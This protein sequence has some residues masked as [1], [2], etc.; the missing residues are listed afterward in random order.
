MNPGGDQE[1]QVGRLLDLVVLVE[2]LFDAVNALPIPIG[3]KQVA[4]SAGDLAVN[5]Q[6]EEEGSFSAFVVD[7]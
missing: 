4:L 1:V 2:A 3:V 6:E 7:V 5:R